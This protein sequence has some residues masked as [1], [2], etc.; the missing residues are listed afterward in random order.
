M[1]KL[2]DILYGVSIESIVGSTALMVDSIEFDSRKINQGALFVA[3]KGVASDGHD[4]IANAILNGAVVVVCERLPKTCQTGIVYVVVPNAS[5][6]L[7][8]IA[9]NFY[10]HPSH[11]LI[12]IG[13]TGTNGKTTIASLLFD[14]FS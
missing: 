9:A 11:K 13:V 14:L 12:L 7:G 3:Q 6:A 2:Q 8:L 1:K 4:F 10:N 5:E